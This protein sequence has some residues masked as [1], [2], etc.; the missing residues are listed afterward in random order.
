MKKI[1]AF[2]IIACMLL[3]VTTLAQ[4][5]TFSKR[6]ATISDLRK[7]LEKQTGYTI[8]N[9]NSVSAKLKPVTVNITNGTVEQLLDE[10]FK[11]QTCT[12]TII[13]KV[14]T[15]IPR[16]TPQTTGNGVINIK[17]KIVNEQGD[18]VPGATIAVKGSNQQTSTTESGDF[19]LTEVKEID[20]IIVVTSINYESEEVSY[21]GEP[22]L[23]VQ[24]KQRINELD[25]VQVVS[26]GYQK[27]SKDKSP[28][29]FVKID[30]ELLNRRVST[31]ILDRLDGIASGLVFNKNV[32]KAVNQ[33]TMSIRGRTTIYANA[34]PLIVVD[35]FPYTGDIN[36]INPNDVESITVL[37]DA[38][39]ASIWGAYS[40]NGVI[41]ITTKKGKYNQALKLSINSNVLVGQ[42]PD[43]YYQPILSSYDYIDVERFLFSKDFYNTRDADPRHPVL[44]PAV[45]IMF[46][47]KRQAISSPIAEEQLNAL[48][49]QD[50]RKDLENY[51]YRNNV[52]QQY[53]LSANGGGSNNNYY[54]SLGYDKN[55]DNLVRNGYDRITLTANNSFSWLKKKLE[56]NTG[57][58]YTES[59]ARLNNDEIGNITYPYLDLVDEFGNARTVPLTLR[60]AYKDTAGKATLDW[61]YKPYNELKYSDNSTKTTDHRINADA[62]YTI[63]KG[64]NVSVFYQYNK[65]F[66]ETEDY[67]SQQTYYTRNYINQFTDTS[68][69]QVIRRVPLG[70]IL[71]QA[72]TQY[73]AHNTRTQI[74]YDHSWYN[75]KQSK[76]HQV[77]A[78][79]GTEVRDLKKYLDFLRLYGYNKDVLTTNSVI[80]DSA[81]SLYHAPFTSQKIA[82]N[83]VNRSETDRYIS[84]YLNAKYIFQRRYILSGS[85]R[86]D[87]SNLFGV[88]TNQKGVPL[89]SVGASWEMNQENFY[90]LGWLP[91]LKLRITNGYKGNVDKSVSAFTTVRNDGI[92]NT[93]NVPTASIVNPPNPSL[94]WE[95][96][97]M[98]NFGV[99]FAIKNSILEGSLEFYT[100]KGTDLIGYSP[101]DPTTGVNIFRGNTADMKGKG[102]DVVLRSKN[103]N[104]RFK[105]YSTFL[106]SYAADEITSYKVPQSAVWYYADPLFMSPMEGKPLYSIFSF[107]WMGLHPQTGDPQGYYNKEASTNY[108]GILNSAELSDLIYRG[109]AN[110]IYFGSLRNNLSY[111]QF[112]LSFNITYKMGYYFRRNSI[113]YF[114]LFNGSLGHS[115][116]LQRWQNPGDENI[117]SIPSMI[118]NATLHRSNFYKYSDVLIEKGDHIRLQ[119]V[120]LSYQL[121]KNEKKWLPMNQV[122]IYV[123]AN[124]LGILWRA[125]KKGIDPDFIS[126]TSIPIPKTIAAGLKIDF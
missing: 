21:Q 59:K 81:F 112:D 122:R 119:D 7:A 42:K 33:S 3:S 14:V 124:N 56:L 102:V 16:G 65:G 86:K 36:N 116:Y 71:D 24:L 111:K 99:D 113:N 53:S 41:V 118:L 9:S 44:S 69:G 52:N 80:Y 40:G 47:E 27:L 10:Y 101:L 120:Q 58:I 91:F 15:V 54:F 100:R 49:N 114:E 103:I 26:T 123:Y 89:W 46:K 2:L 51:F 57:I 29:S 77:T 78:M 85:I 92:S 70:G 4:Q 32:D 28:G 72:T 19:K 1:T 35:N 117:T 20:L 30:N 94:R 105:W 95:K 68:S 31:N 12:Y 93:W 98:I 90:H 64:L 45:E 37:K 18:P 61:D 39:A 13:D 75:R 43:L 17:G 48:R 88:S 107:K 84:Y 96:N 60:Q 83:N 23:N 121:N 74:N 125:N 110:P 76:H 25:K 67:K 66:I 79:A 11:Y 22:E 62:R 126:T 104:K 5:I 82:F 106:L 38:D 73:E 87:E 108:S 6:N 50:K 115:D 97:H 8:F 109:P 34:E 55:L 63:T